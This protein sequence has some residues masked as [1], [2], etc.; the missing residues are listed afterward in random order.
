MFT[1]RDFL[2]GA[3]LIAAG[4]VTA[5]T[6]ELLDKIGWRRRFFPGWSA[7]RY[8]TILDGQGGERI[9]IEWSKDGGKVWERGLWLTVLAPQPGFGRFDPDS[10]LAYQPIGT[11]ERWGG[12]LG[13]PARLV[14]ASG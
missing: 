13:T 3:A 6:L 12:G 2:R 10:S 8:P 1:R 5:D 4:V 11:I 9:A 14:R 7:P